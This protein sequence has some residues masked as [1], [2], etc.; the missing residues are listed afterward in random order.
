M[1]LMVL[2][3]VK[4]HSHK[5]IL[6]R[7]L[8]AVGIRLSATHPST[9]PPPPPHPFSTAEH[10]FSVRDVRCLMN[11]LLQRLSCSAYRP[12]ADPRHALLRPAPR[13]EIDL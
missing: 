9:A 4:P 11:L 13:F 3:A 8:E 7:E 2:D 10:D 6:T 12:F 1:L 5:E